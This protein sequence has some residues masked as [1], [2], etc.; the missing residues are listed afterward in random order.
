[1]EDK[2]RSPLATHWGSMSTTVFVFGWIIGQLGRIPFDIPFTVLDVGVFML[3][4]REVA[5][6]GITVL[7]I[8]S[9]W[10]KVLSI[11]LLTSW[12]LGLRI[13]PLGAS[14]VGLLYLT[15]VIAY[16][17]VITKAKSLFGNSH[18][19][20]H[21][22]L[23]TFLV[24]GLAQFLFLKDMRF[25]FQYGWDEHYWRLVGT[26]LDPNYTGAIAGLIGLFVL[27]D[28]RSLREYFRSRVLLGLSLIVLLLTFSRI[29]WIATMIGTAYIFRKK[30]LQLFLSLSI[31]LLCIGLVVLLP[32]PNSEGTNL[33][34]TVSISQRLDSMKRGILLWQTH[35]FLGV[36]FNNYFA[37][38]RQLFPQFAPDERSHARNA[39]DSS[40]VLL[41]STT[42]VFG[43]AVLLGSLWKPIS[44]LD[45]RWKAILLFLGVHSF[46][47]NTLFFPPVL[48]LIALLT[49]ANTRERL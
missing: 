18:R 37:S 36:G 2:R 41:L 40:W 4:A 14:I 17:W 39:P 26:Q 30:L 15:R 32:K 1:M 28:Q 16:C 45:V 8:Q 35:P 46:A 25:L 29:S 24:L 49:A 11:T 27:S 34:R 10:V 19:M 9:R 31:I 3:L 44:Q 6:R 5:L 21:L 23:I 33:L 38:M 12:V 7:T 43:I 42:G 48:A 13:S 20:S 22:I 47:N